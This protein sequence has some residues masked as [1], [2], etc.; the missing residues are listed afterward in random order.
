MIITYFGDSCFRLQSGELSLLVDPNS[1]RLKGDVV[2]RTLTATNAELVPEE[3]AFAGEYES[4]GIEING[5]QISK[6][7][8]DKSVKTVFRVS[9]EEMKF[10]FLG[11]LSGDLPEDIL[12]EVSEPDI[13]FLPVGGGNFLE[14]SDAARI[15]KQLEPS[16][17]IPSLY[18][19]SAEF[20]KAMGQKGESQDKF[21]FKKKDL[22]EMKSQVVVLDSKGA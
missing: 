12:E 21:V 11:N 7:S 2:L 22:K 16:V 14:A 1:N 9:W 3:I 19:N 6:E 13:L 15:V 18:K 4:K 20:L 17:A 5:F 10:V 8:T